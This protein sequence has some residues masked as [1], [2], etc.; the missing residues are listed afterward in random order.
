MAPR[1]GLTTL[2][3]LPVPAAARRGSPTDCNLLVSD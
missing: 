3:C 1:S 2:R